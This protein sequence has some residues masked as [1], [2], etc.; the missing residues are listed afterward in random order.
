MDGQLWW[1]LLGL[2][3]LA[4][5]LAALITAAQCRRWGYVVAIAIL[6]PFGVAAWFL[7]PAWSRRPGRTR[8]P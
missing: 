2:I 5:W 8:V 3:G 1:D 6:G 4:A 7:S